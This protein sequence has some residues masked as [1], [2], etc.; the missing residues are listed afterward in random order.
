LQSIGKDKYEVN[1][2]A[3]IDSLLDDMKYY[4]EPLED[5]YGTLAHCF[6]FTT[7]WRENIEIPSDPEGTYR[8][9]RNMVGIYKDNAIL[10]LSDS[11]ITEPDGRVYTTRDINN[12][13]TVDILTQ[14]GGRQLDKDHASLWIHSW[15]GAVGSQ[16]NATINADSLE[17][18]AI[19]GLEYGF[20]L[21]DAEGDGVLEIKNLEVSD[22]SLTWSWNGSQYG[23]WPSTPHVSDT[24]WLPRNGIDVEVNCRIQDISGSLKYYYSVRNKPTSKQR[25]DEFYVQLLTDSVQLEIPANWEQIVHYL[26]HLQG[27]GVPA[28][29]HRGLILPQQRGSGF[30]II[31]EGLPAVNKFYIQAENA[32]PNPE[33]M[34]VAEYSIGLERDIVENSIQGLTVSPSNYPVPCVALTFLDTLSSYTTQS[35][36]PGWIKDQSTANKYLGY[37][38]SAKTSLQQSNIAS[39][40]ATLQQ[41]LEDANV[42]STANI[43]SEAYALIRYNTEYLLSEIPAAPIAGCNVKLINSTGAKL[44]GGSLQYYDGGWKDAINNN[45]GTFFVST[46]A[47]T[48]SLR[49][50]YEYGTQTKSNVTVGPDTVAFQTVNAQIQLQDSRGSLIDTGTVQ[51]YGG[52]WRSLGTT[53]SGVALKELLPGNYSFRMTYAYASKDKQQDIGSNPTVVFQTVN[54]SVQ[55]QNSQGTLMPA[56][57]GD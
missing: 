26:F 49:M 9:Q 2:I 21:F 25:I 29:N 27:W 57:L 52:A 28:F 18:S 51:Y 23:T 6:I 37:F 53:I 8:S 7:R 38:S 34:T 1:D 54:A 5:P 48:I 31:A 3:D 22:G 30:N 47:R 10:W 17:E 50:T 45:D 11:V 16:I 55:L 36:T 35:R 20:L 32:A 41:V 12:D 33:L 13:G 15:N 46:S 40:R 56:P 42:D 14:W 39:T 4:D 24:V 19:I 44:T 43:A